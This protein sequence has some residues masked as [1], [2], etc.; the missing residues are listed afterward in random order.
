MGLAGF[1]HNGEQ[2][3]DLRTTFGG[4]VGH[5]FQMTNNSVVAAYVGADWNNEHYEG[6]P[7][8]Q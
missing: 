4:A 2:E 3:L 7:T 6:D 5:N 8:L 1:Q